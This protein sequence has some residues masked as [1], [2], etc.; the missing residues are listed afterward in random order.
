MKIQYVF[1]HKRDG[2]IQRETFTLDEIEKG[3][4]LAYVDGMKQD[5]YALINRIFVEYV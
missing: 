3:Q 5:G 1:K 2:D 4:S